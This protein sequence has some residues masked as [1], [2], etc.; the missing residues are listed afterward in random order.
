M[1]KFSVNI[2]Q[3]PIK[4][5]GFHVL[6]GGI[7]GQGMLI[8]DGVKRPVF[9]VYHG[10]KHKDRVVIFYTYYDDTKIWF[11]DQFA[12]TNSMITAECA[13]RRLNVEYPP[14]P[15]KQGS[16]LILA[17]VPRHGGKSAAEKFAVQCM[18]MH[19]EKIRR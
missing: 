7:Y 13:I 6:K 1:V 19:F 4:F 8:V 14:K 2:A 11:K 15:S 9:F 18:S 17:E 5:H 12:V 16:R 3:K 10:K